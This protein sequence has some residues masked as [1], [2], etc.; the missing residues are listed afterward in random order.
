MG[1]ERFFLAGDV[2]FELGLEKHVSE[3]LCAS[4]TCAAV[5][6]QCGALSRLCTSG[7]FWLWWNR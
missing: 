4:V 3:H 5:R 6:A 7:V 1:A 2:N